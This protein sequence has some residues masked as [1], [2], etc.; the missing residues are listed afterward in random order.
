[1]FRAGLRLADYRL[2][3][4]RDTDGP[5]LFASHARHRAPCVDRRCAAWRGRRRLAD[6]TGHRG[7]SRRRRL[8]CSMRGC[9]GIGWP[10]GRCSIR[11]SCFA[12]AAPLAL[13]VGSHCFGAPAS[14]SPWTAA[15]WPSGCS[16]RCFIGTRGRCRPDNST[17]PADSSAI[18]LVLPSTAAALIGIG[19]A[20]A[21]LAT[22]RRLFRCSRCPVRWDRERPGAWRTDGAAAASRALPLTPSSE[23]VPQGPRPRLVT[24]PADHRSPRQAPAPEP[25]VA[26]ARRGGNCRRAASLPA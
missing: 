6:R 21:S 13:L 19:I 4:Y 11:R 25:T 18:L 3:Q 20:L 10:P 14:R 15:R 17:T 9:S 8:P 16:S 2:N 26:G 24:M 22:P 7:R 23:S 12:G 1:M 5:C